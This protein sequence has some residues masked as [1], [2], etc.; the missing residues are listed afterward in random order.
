M[1]PHAGPASASLD[2]FKNTR[3]SLSRI[4]GAVQPALDDPTHGR[5]EPPGPLGV[6]WWWLEERLEGCA[7]DDGVQGTPKGVWSSSGAGMRKSFLSRL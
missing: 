4:L 7:E 5:R 6:L 2:V 3:R 1:L